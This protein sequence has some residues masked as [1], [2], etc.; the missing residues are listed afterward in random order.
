MSPPL[1]SIIV[2]CYNAERWLAATLESALAQTWPAKEIVVVNDGST[3]GSLIVARTFES[4]G[5][6]VLDQANAGAS[7]ARNAGWRA[8]HGDF[9]QFLDADDLL[10]PDKIERQLAVLRAAPG[11]VASC[12]WGRFSGDPAATAFVPCALWADFAPVDWLVH[13]WTT[14]EMMHPAAWLTPRPVAA[15]AGPWNEQVSLDDDGEF[16]SRVVL[17][18]RGVKFTAGTAAFYRT[19]DGARLSALSGRRAAQSSFLSSELKERHLL[20][21]EDSR[22]TRRALAVR[23]AQFAWDQLGAAPDLAARAIARWQRL[24]PDV[25]PPAAGP[26]TEALID[27]VG[28]QAARR[29]QLL[30]RRQP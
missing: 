16:F 27:V 6:R 13:S 26:L 23:Y 28:W 5:V 19:H 22:R 8:A 20:A 1:V 9:L 21:A 11:C 17:A 15:A 12:A 4:R 25:P 10:A 2:P 29:L 18:S 24:A 30:F 7:A 14:S 3:D